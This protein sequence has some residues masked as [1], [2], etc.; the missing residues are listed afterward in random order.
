MK[1]YKYIT[2]RREHNESF[3]GHPV[4]RVFNNKSGGQLAII[5]WYRPW[6]QYVFSS[7]EECVFNNSCLRDVLDFIENRVGAEMMQAQR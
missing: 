2:I 4:Y 1:K 5:S 3:E 6:K 7:M